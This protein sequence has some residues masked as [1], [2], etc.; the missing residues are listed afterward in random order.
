MRVV[1]KFVSINGEGQRAGEP[2]AFVRF[3]GCNL[4]CSWC[5][6]KWA[7]EPDCPYEEMSPAE[8]AAW[9]DETG[10]TNVTL[11][12]GE[13]LLQK[14]MGELLPLLLADKKHRVEIETNGS[15]DISPFC[16]KARPAFTLDYKLPGS[17]CEARMNT[18]N[19]GL[20]RPED[21]VKFVIGS[22]EDLER[23]KEIMEQYGLIGRCQ[24]YLS[25]VFGQIEPAEMA[26]F[27]TE[28]RMNGVRMQ[29][30]IHKV[31]WDPEKRGV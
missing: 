16:I 7:N 20:L 18:A 6:T 2:A 9:A 1:E 24:V 12:G 27:L 30:Q 3:Q 25:P 10:I 31:I 14:E 13:P 17:G 21:T 15:V 19:Y 11:T 23:A 5:D 22:R 26:E 28:H 29:I 4:C 8:V